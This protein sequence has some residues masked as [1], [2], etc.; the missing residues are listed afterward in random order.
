MTEDKPIER[1]IVAQ[2]EN[3]AI[4][5]DE[6]KA[7]HKH[8]HWMWYIFPQIAG[9]GQSVTSRFYALQDMAGGKSLPSSSY[10]W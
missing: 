8:S 10:S 1:F 2:N 9:L 5:F 7:G 3:Y 6:V 4:A